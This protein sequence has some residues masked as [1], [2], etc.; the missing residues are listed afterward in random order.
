MAGRDKYA[1]DGKDAVD[2]RQRRKEERKARIERRGAQ[3]SEADRPG[4]ITAMQ[5]P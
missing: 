3:R 2:D 1:F 4:G 5:V